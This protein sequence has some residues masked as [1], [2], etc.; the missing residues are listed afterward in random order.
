MGADRRVQ[1]P[2]LNKVRQEDLHEGVDMGDDTGSA[3]GRG[4]GSFLSRN[5][6]LLEEA[7]RKKG[8]VALPGMV[9]RNSNKSDSPATNMQESESPAAAPT[10]EQIQKALTPTLPLPGAA[11][12]K[13]PYP[14]QFSPPSA[15]IMQQLS[16][17][18]DNTHDGGSDQAQ[19]EQ[20]TSA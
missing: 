19:R 3:A 18:D 5:P 12:P 16:L 13:L 8:G 11:S 9:A 10:G 15:G 2:V 17:Q 20:G 4:V 7:R 1:G 6:G 14:G